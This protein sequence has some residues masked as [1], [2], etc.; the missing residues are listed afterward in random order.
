MPVLNT[1]DVTWAALQY[2]TTQS[3]ATQSA[4]TRAQAD[5]LLVQKAL[6]V[7]YPAFDYSSGPGLFGARTTAQYSTY[8]MSLGFTGDDA[9]GVPGVTS[10][11]ALGQRTGV[12]TLDVDA[13]PP[14][15][16]PSPLAPITWPQ[17]N[18]WNLKGTFASGPAACRDFTTRA[19]T[20]MGLPVTSGWLNGMA[21]IALRESASNSPAWQINTTDSNAKNV[22]GIFNGGNAP[23]GFKGQCSRGGWQCIP[24]TFCANHAR[25]T[26]NSIYDPVSS[27]GASINYVRRQYGVA[28]DGHDLAAKVQQ[29]DPNRPPKGY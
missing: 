2:N 14:P 24:Q 22:P 15:P 21:T 25:G 13:P 7:V 11:R 1:G 28:D 19:L 16:P 5:V 10:M 27:V 18:G 29:A 23:D 8:Q 3:T 12:F 26:S 4:D 9:S 17:M 6:K 20:A